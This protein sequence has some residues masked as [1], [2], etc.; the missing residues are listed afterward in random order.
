MCVG[1]SSSIGSK[2]RSAPFPHR[3]T[4]SVRASHRP[5]I[6]R[7]NRRRRRG[8]A[9]ERGGREFAHRTSIRH[10]V[11]SLSSS[12]NS[13]GDGQPMT[14]P[15]PARRRLICVWSVEVIGEFRS[16]L[17]RF[18][19][20]RRCRFS[21]RKTVTATDRA[22]DQIAAM[23][24]CRPRGDRTAPR[25]ATA[26][27]D[28]H[29]LRHAREGWVDD[30]SSRYRNRSSDIASVGVRLH[31]Q[32]AHPPSDADGVCMDRGGRWFR[33]WGVVGGH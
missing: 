30:A 33:R 21:R 1:S 18:S 14:T 12:S 13:R 4:S 10:R 15:P 32:L 28:I 16:D 29:Q 19:R 22:D 6:C 3:R 8:G 7:R 17:E 24:H 26:D 11:R 5:T 31:Q 27:A 2:R 23:F 20:R 25:L 9:G